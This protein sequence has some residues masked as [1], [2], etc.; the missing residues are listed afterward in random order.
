VAGKE[1]CELIITGIG[2]CGLVHHDEANRAA[3]GLVGS[4]SLS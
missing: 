4:Y 1:P 2:Q 3:V